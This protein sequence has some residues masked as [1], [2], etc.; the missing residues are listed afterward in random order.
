[1]VYTGTHDNDTTRGWWVK[2][3]ESEK[4]AF[5]VY[6]H[7]DPSEESFAWMLT[8]IAFGSRA[9]LA[10]VP[11]QDLLNLGSEARM[12]LPGTTG[13]HNWTWRLDPEALRPE[14]AQRLRELTERTGR[15]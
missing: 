7:S 15:A 1:M 6:T 11:L 3:D 9:V 14:L 8:E 12:N 10:V 13:D 4:H 5:R 2:A